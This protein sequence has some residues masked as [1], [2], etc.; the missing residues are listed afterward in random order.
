AKTH[1]CVALGKLQLQHGARG[2]TVSTLVEAEA[3]ARAGVTDLTWAFPIDPGHVAHA[4]RIGQET[5][6]TLR[7]VVDDL[8]AAQA[9][10]DSGL[11][12]WLK[13][14]CRYHRAGVEPAS[15]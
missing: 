1:K 4:R 6:A 15:D 9:L 12:V 2:L 11:P 5:G 7:V 14:D 3:F 13:V 10:A 8:G